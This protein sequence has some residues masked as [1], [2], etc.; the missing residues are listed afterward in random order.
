VWRIKMNRTRREF[1]KTTAGTSALLSLSA[2]VPSVLTRA[3]AA[4]ESADRRNTVLVVLQLSGATT[5]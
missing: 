5:G 1:L 2:A 3:A 4:A